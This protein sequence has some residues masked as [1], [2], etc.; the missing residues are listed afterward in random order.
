VMHVMSLKIQSC[1]NIFNRM[2][3]VYPFISI[4]QEWK[5]EARD[6]AYDLTIAAWNM[7]LFS[8]ATAII[9]RQQNRS[10]Y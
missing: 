2:R 3:N 4:N 9:R 10:F 6:Q 5:P 8:Y 7:N 1:E